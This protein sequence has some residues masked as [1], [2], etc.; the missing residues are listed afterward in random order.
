MTAARLLMEAVVWIGLGA[1]S[2][3]LLA[4]LTS[5]DRRIHDRAAACMAFGTAAIVLARLDAIA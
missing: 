1:N 5:D 2:V 4:M 3:G